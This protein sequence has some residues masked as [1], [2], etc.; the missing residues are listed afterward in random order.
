MR[1]HCPTVAE[2]ER[3]LGDEVIGAHRSDVEITG[4][5]D[6]TEIDA[7]G[8]A[9]RSN[10]ETRCASGNSVDVDVLEVSETRSGTYGD[11]HL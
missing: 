1:R 8:H 9:S 7:V 4:G 5:T 3:Y 11:S 2:D 10:V 6:A